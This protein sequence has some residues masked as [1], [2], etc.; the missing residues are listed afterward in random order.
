[1]KRASF[2]LFIAFLLIVGILQ[3]Q[4]SQDS[5]KNNIF[6]ALST[7]DSSTHATVK[8]HQDKRI[9]QLLANK[10]YTNS[11]D[12][13]M[14]N[15]FRVQVFSSNVQ[16]TAKNEAFR[17]EKQIQDAFPNE[18]VYVN[19]SSPFWKVRVGDYKTQADAQKFKNQLIET[20]PN[21]KSEIYIVRE[22]IQISS[23]K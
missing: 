16:R 4:Q 9:D 10:R 17:I 14:T 22:Q 12:Q 20:F 18:A 15:G 6:D 21:L 13:E 5:K 7:T 1:M 23:S 11:Q 3:A 8:V 19:Y 2:S